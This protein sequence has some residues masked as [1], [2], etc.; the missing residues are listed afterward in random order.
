M[1]EGLEDYVVVMMDNC[2]LDYSEV[3]TDRPIFLYISSDYAGFLLCGEGG[4]IVTHSHT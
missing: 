3:A 1:G 2:Q 4:I